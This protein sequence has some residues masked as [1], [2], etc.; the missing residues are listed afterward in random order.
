[1]EWDMGGYGLAFAIDPSIG[2]TMFETNSGAAP[3]GKSLGGYSNPSMDQWLLKA[4]AS[5]S[6]ID[7]AKYYREAEKVLL[8][9]A[10]VIPCFPMRMVIGWNKKVQGVK[11]TDTLGINVT[12]T[13]ANMWLEQ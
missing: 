4:G 9:D 12:N 1:M 3:D 10:A 8:Q 7:R 6:E 5:L 13:W 11:V 2:F